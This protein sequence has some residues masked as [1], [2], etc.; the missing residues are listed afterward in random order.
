[1]IVLTMSRLYMTPLAICKHASR[2]HKTP[3]YVGH[4][5]CSFKGS[6]VAQ[7]PINSV[8]I[9]YRIKYMR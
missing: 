1:M 4:L 8:H 9:I 7:T 6:Y 2:Q 3:S 5:S